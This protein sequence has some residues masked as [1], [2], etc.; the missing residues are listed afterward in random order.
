[1]TTKKDSEGLRGS[2]S[3]AYQNTRTDIEELTLMRVQ[4]AAALMTIERLIEK[5]QQA[6]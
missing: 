5:A 6:S 3:D 4:L 1:M 2:V